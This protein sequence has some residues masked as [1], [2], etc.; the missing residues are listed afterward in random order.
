MVPKHHF[1]P[2]GSQGLKMWLG[3][4]RR[5]IYCSHGIPTRIK[6]RKLHVGPFTRPQFLFTP[7]W[8]GEK[9]RDLGPG[10]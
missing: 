1:L 10:F 9:E 7:Y 4:T 2:R 5:I 3:K 8:K 6:V